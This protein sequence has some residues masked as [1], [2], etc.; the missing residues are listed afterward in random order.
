[1]NTSIFKLF[2][3]L[4]TTAVISSS[5]NAQNLSESVTVEGKYKPEFISAD[6]LA[7]LPNI[8]TLKAPESSLNYDRIGMPANFSPDALSMPATGWGASKIYDSS[9]GYL[10]IRLGSWLNSSLST[11]LAA[12]NNADTRLNL[13]FQ[14]NSTSLWQAW[15][16]NQS[17]HSPA[18][19]NRFRYDETL[20]A[21]LNQRIAGAGTLDARIQYHL[22]Y[23]NYYGS[24]SISQ[25]DEKIK[26]PTQTLNDFYAGANWS[27]I[28]NSLFQYGVRADMRYFAYR[29]M[30]NISSY[31]LSPA[32]TSA[33]G[34]R[35]SVVNLGGDITYELNSG[36]KIGINML[37]S[38]V[39]NSIG[40][41]VNRVRF[42]PAYNMNAKNYSF[43]IGIDLALVANGNTKFR[44]APDVNFSLRNGISAFSAKIGGGTHLRTL[45]WMHQMDYYANP[46]LGCYNAAYSPIDMSLAYQL[47]PGG[48]WSFGIEGR[49]CSTLDECF[50]GLYQAYLNGNATEYKIGDIN[51][52]HGFSVAI[53]GGY[54]FSRYFRI[55]GKFS[56]QPQHGTSG[57]LNGFDRP[58]LT[59]DFSAESHPIDKLS[60]ALNYGLRAKR[61]LLPGNISRLNLT[62]DYRITEKISVGAELNNLLNRKEM[63]L[64]DLPEE[65]L[66]ALAGVQIVF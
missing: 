33:K 50:G 27:G 59:A 18:A 51:K 16:E 26:A 5:A 12:I 54:E 62:V 19:D 39:I 44:I 37:Y 64:P 15:K 65:G 31:S 22:G 49:W 36:S 57:I 17:T 46:S 4:A 60:I 35:E 21:N 47:N 9:K 38:G 1:M 53:N 66:N 2:F 3:A 41:N 34:E 6:R 24:K 28:T 61:F 48:K 58:V 55:N 13:Y 42:I 43:R 63:I 25:G 11:G 8:L 30:Y 29:S 14:H 45:A 40:N 7:I 20:G 56:W 52:I 32:L 10:N 23:F